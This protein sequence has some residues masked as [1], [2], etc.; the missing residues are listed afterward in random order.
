MH[1]EVLK[2]FRKEPRSEFAEALRKRLAQQ[3]DTDLPP[4]SRSTDSSDGRGDSEVQEDQ[5]D[6]NVNASLHFAAPPRRRTY[7]REGRLVTLVAAVA[8]IVIGL[9]AFNALYNANV[10]AG[11]FGRTV[12]TPTSLFTRY[13][14]EAWNAGKTTFSPTRWRRH[15][16]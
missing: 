4:L 10:P 9:G 3:A 11:L 15:V 16:C 2:Q 12:E 13:I 14:N 7:R 8:A 5:E 6:K 1:D